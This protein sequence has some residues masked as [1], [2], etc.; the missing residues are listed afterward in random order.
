MPSGANLKK[1]VAVR[2]RSPHRKCIQRL[3]SDRAAFS[4]PGNPGRSEA[5]PGEEVI[6]VRRTTSISAD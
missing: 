1:H 6:S 5:E 4:I 2:S 3:D